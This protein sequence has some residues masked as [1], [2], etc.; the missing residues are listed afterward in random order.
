[1]RRFRSLVNSL[2]RNPEHLRKYDAVIQHQL[3]KE[4]IEATP[5]E[6]SANTLKNY[7]PHHEIVTPENT[8]TKIRV[9]FDASAKTRKGNKCLNETLHRGSIIVED[10]YGLFMRFRLNKVSLM[11]DRV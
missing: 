3:E 1:M 8:T 6:Y 9:L 4:I 2:L 5:E 7:I 11:A 10:L